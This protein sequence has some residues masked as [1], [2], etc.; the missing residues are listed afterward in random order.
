MH[1]EAARALAMQFHQNN[2]HLVYGGGTVGLMGE[3]AKTLV[4]LSGPGA[5]HGVIPRALIAVEEGYQDKQ[6]LETAKTPRG[7]KIERIVGDEKSAAFEFGMI[8]VVPDMHTRKH[9]MATKVRGGG[10]GS[11]FIAMAGGFGTM[12]EV[13]EMTTWNQLGI[14]PVGVVL[15]NIDG[16][17]DAL[18]AWMKHAVQE[19]FLSERHAGILAETS[20]VD[21]ILAMLREYQV[22]EDGLKLAWGRE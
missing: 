13:M 7:A 4:S 9:L 19:G 12:E 1:L 5:V 2:V 10:P 18:V 8:T 6:L 21:Q 3:L 17:W 14:Q 20:N 11:G 22:G 16:Y 15:L